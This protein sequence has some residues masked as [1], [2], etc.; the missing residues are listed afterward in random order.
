MARASTT[1]PKI[2]LELRRRTKKPAPQAQAEARVDPYEA[3]GRVLSKSL[4]AMAANSGKFNAV[5]VFVPGLGT[6]EI[7]PATPKQS[8]G[9][10]PFFYGGQELLNELKEKQKLAPDA[11]LAHGEV[12]RFDGAAFTEAR[13]VAPSTVNQRETISSLAER[14]SDLAES[15]YQRLSMLCVRVG[16]KEAVAPAAPTA[17]R[18]ASAPVIRT[19]D[20]V[21]IYLREVHEAI[22]SLTS[23]I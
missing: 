10:W 12:G 22:D 9:G 21:L 11:P 4:N 13:T 5:S 7:A 18:A 1:A 2:K 17:P 19:I 6:V 3:L 23:A 16:T 8:S 20:D 14:A 15:A